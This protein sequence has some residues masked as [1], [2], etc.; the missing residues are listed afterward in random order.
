MT[1]KHPNADYCEKI[2]QRILDA[3]HEQRMKSKD[4]ICV[5]ELLLLTVCKASNIPYSQF[6]EL[7]DTLKTAYKEHLLDD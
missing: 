4:A 2:A 5:I 6:I 7:C 1:H 3:M